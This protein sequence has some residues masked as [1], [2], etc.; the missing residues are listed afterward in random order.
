VRRSPLPREQ[1]VT[2]RDIS[3]KSEYWTPVPASREH[4]REQ[5]LLEPDIEWQTAP[6]RKDPGLCREIFS[7]HLFRDIFS[8]TKWGG[9]QQREFKWRHF[10]KEV[11]LW[12][13]RSDEF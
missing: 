13:I 7:S 1:K 11:I 3:T 2:L 6:W 10:T 9:G 12:S 8:I 4:K 5:L